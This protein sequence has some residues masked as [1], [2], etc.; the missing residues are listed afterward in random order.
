MQPLSLWQ[1]IRYPLQAEIR[2]LARLKS[3]WLQPVL[4]FCLLVTLFPL[5]L[6]AT[7]DTIALLMPTL[8]WIAVSLS[9]LWSA[10][11]A[12]QL[13]LEE[14]ALE[15]V[16]LS[17]YPVWLWLLMRGIAYWLVVVLPMV[18]LGPCLAW[19]LGLEQAAA[20]VLAWT[21]WLGTPG[22]TMLALIASGL[23]LCLRNNGL[24]LILMML[25]LFI[26]FLVF[27]VGSVNLSLMGIWPASQL[28][29]LGALSVFILT[30][31]P[32]AGGLGIQY[33]LD[34]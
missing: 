4:F 12:F 26:P 5:G 2:L 20:K 6:G 16:V 18:V 27:G 15:Q 14:G 13:D 19:V 9:A 1:W 25:P 32:F 31:G 8:V 24:L 30:F 33:S 10:E 23:T 7:G 29:W 22:L 17:A 3:R 11:S 28:A 21:L 34:D